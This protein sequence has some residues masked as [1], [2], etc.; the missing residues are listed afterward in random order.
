MKRY[1]HRLAGTLRIKSSHFIAGISGLLVIILI[2]L[3]IG[4][5]YGIK[6]LLNNKYLN[7]KFTE[8][9]MKD[10]PKEDISTELP[11]DKH[12]HEELKKVFDE[13]RESTE[14]EVKLNSWPNAEIQIS[15]ISYIRRN[16]YRHIKASYTSRSD[17]N[18]LSPEV[19]F[20]DFEFEIR[21]CKLRLRPASGRR[22]SPFA[23]VML[24]ILRQQTQSIIKSATFAEPISWPVSDNAHKTM[25][26]E[27]NRFLDLYLASLKTYL[28]DSDKVTGRIQYI[29]YSF[30]FK[31]GK[32]D[33]ATIRVSF[34]IKGTTDRYLHP[35]LELDYKE[36]KFRL[37]EDLIGLGSYGD[38]RYV[39]HANNSAM[40][41]A[42][43]KWVK[44]FN[45]NNMFEDARIVPPFE[46][47]ETGKDLPHEMGRIVQIRRRCH[48]FLRE[49]DRKYRIELSDGRS[50][51]FRLPADGGSVTKTDVYL[52]QADGKQFIR[53][54]DDSLTD[55]VIAIDSFKICAPLVPSTSNLL[56]TFKE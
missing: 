23:D 51:T 33:H 45:S 40:N 15:R 35:E 19:V 28:E 54:E 48:P 4:G 7:K 13:I 43:E 46:W 49:Y 39:K 34:D 56:F 27:A 32:E 8:W 18:L 24:P 11:L 29:K 5:A 36:G 1:R 12:I 42:V 52:I 50:K 25:L 6:G 2:A 10:W 44:T 30:E 37:V 21:D 31:K 47:K 14:R 3:W 17:T 38:V 26:N 16:S 9:V 55:I 53:L 41:Y 22:V 20:G